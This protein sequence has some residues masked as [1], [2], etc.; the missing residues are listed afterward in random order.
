M[1]VTGGSVQS[2]S[3]GG[4]EF[5]ADAGTKPTVSLGGV[6]VEQK[7]NGKGTHRELYTP[8]NWMISGIE[9]ELDLE[10]GDW[11]YLVNFQL[12]GGGEIIITYAGDISYIGVGNITDKLDANPSEASISL[13]C[14]GGQ[15]LKKLA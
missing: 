15:F 13:S 9:V 12:G 3:L 6:S 5:K 2:I 11:E 8:I 7:M 14:G 10:N 1:T 4:R